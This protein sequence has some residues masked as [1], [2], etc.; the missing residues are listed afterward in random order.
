M[1]A[2]KKL[3]I[4]LFPIALLF[5]MTVHTG[6]A[7]DY[8]YERKPQDTFL[9]RDT[10]VAEPLFLP[11]CRACATSISIADSTWIF[12]VNKAYA[13]GRSGKALISPDRTSFTFFG[14][15]A[16]SVDTGFVA[17]VYLTEALDA[18][19]T[20]LRASMAFYYYDNI[21]P[22]YVL[23]SHAGEP[24]SLTVEAYNHQT[25][26]ATGYFSGNAYTATGISKTVSNGKFR[27]QF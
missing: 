18:N 26:I 2:Y 10:I 14:P 5:L 4:V 13:C 17:S 23:V 16:C 22:S 24:F 9:L 3:S 12:N 21:T 8:S 20:N 1:P 7:R 11:A 25:G 19:K 6:C 27:I 15:S